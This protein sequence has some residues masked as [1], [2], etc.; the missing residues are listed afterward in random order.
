MLFKD[1]EGKFGFAKNNRSFRIVGHPEAIP[2]RPFVEVAPPLPSNW[3][4]LNLSL[5]TPT[6]SPDR[7]S[8]RDGDNNEVAIRHMCQ[9]LAGQLQ[10]LLAGC[11]RH[12]REYERAI[13]TCC[14]SIYRRL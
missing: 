2:N 10:Q 8:W 11:R 14:E 12:N 5:G 13:F 3:A 4:W 1:N 9:L 6:R 7:S